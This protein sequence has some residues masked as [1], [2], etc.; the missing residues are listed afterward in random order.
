MPHGLHAVDYSRGA[1]ATLPSPIAELLQALGIEA[2]VFDLNGGGDS[3]ETTIEELRYRDGRVA[4]EIPSIPI[5]I[6][7]MGAV[8]TLPLYLGELAANVPDGD[9]VNNE[10]GYGTVTILP[11]APDASERVSSD[12]TYRDYDGEDDSDEDWDQSLKMFDV[13]DPSCDEASACVTILGEL[14]Q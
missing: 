3:G 5:G 2:I 7:D 14:E 6:T 1:P 13:A 12:M 4:F 8:A 11:F 10:G 9:W